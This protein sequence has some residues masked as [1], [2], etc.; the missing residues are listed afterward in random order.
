MPEISVITTVHGRLDHLRQ[1]RRGLARQGVHAEHVVVQ[2]GGP[3]PWPDVV[4]APAVVPVEIPVD[5]DEQG[6][7][8]LPLAAA[9]N[10]GAA[11]AVGDL[12]VFLDVDCIPSSQ[13]LR[14]YAAAARTA[15]GLLCGP[16]A[17]LPEDFDARVANEAALGAAAAPH[18]ARPDPPAGQLL[19]EDR[20]ELF[21]SL[22]FA[23][24]RGD[25]E[26]LGGFCEEF[27]GYG[28]E[29]TDLAFMA[30]ELGTPFT[31]VGGAVAWH[32][33]HPTQNPPRQHVEAIVRNATVFRERWGTWPMQGWL[34]DFAQEGLVHWDPDRG[35]LRLPGD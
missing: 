11:A 30:R 16:V 10:A 6:R 33:Y 35:E 23:I 8:R 31:W 20:Y 17:Y 22:S 3:S 4:G 25:Y 24:R 21:W 26:A 2:M 32:Q 13:L 28:A 15:R 27:V 9:R 19:G 12:L 29:D 5:D 7:P 1:M 34:R 14:R 18:P